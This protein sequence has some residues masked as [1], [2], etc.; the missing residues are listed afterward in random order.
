VPPLPGMPGILKCVFWVSNSGPHA[1]EADTLPTELCPQPH[2][3]LEGGVAGRAGRVGDR[4]SLCTPG[5]PGT[6]RYLMV[7]VS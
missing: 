5:W 2:T 6:H 7:S 1:F 3:F 4:I